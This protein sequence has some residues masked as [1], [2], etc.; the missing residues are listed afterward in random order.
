MRS[1]PSLPSLLVRWLLALGHVRYW[2]LGQRDAWLSGGSGTLATASACE[3][4]EYSGTPEPRL[5]VATI[6][7]ESA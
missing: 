4:S 5:T 6:V 1:A 2:R 3:R 7:T